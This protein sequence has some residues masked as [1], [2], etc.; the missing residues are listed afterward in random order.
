MKNIMPFKEIKG[1]TES[2]FDNIDPDFVVPKK[3]IAYLMTTKPYMMCMGIYKHPFKEMKLLGPYWYCDGE[4][5]WDRDAW[6]YVVKYHV[7]LPEEFIAKVM[8]DEGTEFLE[9]CSNSDESWTKEIDKL[10]GR[11]NTLC[12]LPDDAGDLKLDDF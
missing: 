12:L 10:K 4:Y 3:V 8:S 11:P 7:K 1:G 9:K 6:K 5:Y 2:I